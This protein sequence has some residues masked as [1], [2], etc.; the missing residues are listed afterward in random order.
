MG[1]GEFLKKIIEKLFQLIISQEY[2]EE[3]RT[4][5]K[6]FTRNR[7]LPFPQ[8]LGV[9]LDNA[10]CG[11]KTNLE[12]FFAKMEM[13][14]MVYSSQAFSK[15][16][17]YIKPTA[18]LSLVRYIA[19]SLYEDADYKTWS[20]YL[21]LAIDG[22][23]CNLPCTSKTEEFFGA[24]ETAGEPQVQA[25]CS[26]LYDVLNNMIVDASINPCTSNER[27]LAVAH[28]DS[29]RKIKTP[30]KGSVVLFDRGYPSAYL[31]D[32]LEK[33]NLKYIMRFSSGFLPLDQYQGKDCIVNHR[34]SKKKTPTNFRI[35]NFNVNGTKEHLITNLFDPEI[36]VDDFQQLYHQR[37]G[38][39]TAYRTLKSTMEIE[40][41]SGTLPVA[42]SQDFYATLFCYNLMSVAEFEMQ[43]EFN[44]MH[45]NRDNKL[46]YKQNRKRV[47]DALKPRV[48]KMLL[49]PEYLA[50]LELA[51]I[52]AEIMK[53]V[54]AV[55]HGRSFQRKKNMLLLNFFLRINALPLKLMTL[56]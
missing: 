27:H 41:F 49:M 30:G 20:D 8:L 6:Y 9:I 2:L 48:V 44:A 23:R 18:I 56:P 13:N 45:N 46:Q 37:W 7:T 38:I 31:I 5:A 34:F 53:S 4:E 43:D 33:R 21:L 40:N 42:I 12:Q 3:S 51:M 11:I 19:Q 35:L 39:E 47:I 22:T 55:R 28:L 29:L 26:C 17:Q 15:Q 16:R 52:S 14:H 25:L 36:T 10:K 50:G 32:E 54:S 24:Q 1:N